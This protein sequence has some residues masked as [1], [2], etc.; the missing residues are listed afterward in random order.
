MDRKDCSKGPAGA[1][2]GAGGNACGDVTG[3]GGN[4]GGGR[5]DIMKAPG[6]DGAYISR[7]GFENNTKGYF[8]ALHAKEKASNTW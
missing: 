8:D 7:P 4:A 1:A 2:G 6:G 5:N 3:K